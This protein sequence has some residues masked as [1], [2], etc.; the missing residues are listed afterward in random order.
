MGKKEK[1]GS[2]IC[3][4]GYLDIRQ[5]IVLPKIKKGF[6]GE[7]IKNPG[8]MEAFVYHGKHKVAGPFKAHDVARIT[9]QELIDKNYKFN[10]NK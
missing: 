8:S 9:A 7:I 5:V 10:K 1:Y 6:R 2:Y 3:K 4:V